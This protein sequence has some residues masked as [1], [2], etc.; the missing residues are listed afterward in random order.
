MWQRR[1]GLLQTQ[2]NESLAAAIEL[3]LASPLFRELGPDAR[4]LI[5]VVA[6]FPQG[7]DE[8]NLEWLFPT[9]SNR[10]SIFDRFCI[11]SLTHRSNGFITMLAPL[12]DYLSPDDPKM[13]PLLLATKEHYFSRM[14]VRIHP[15][16]PNF[17]ATQWITSEDVNVEHLLDVF[18]TIDTNSD[19]IWV[20]CINFMVHLHWNKKRLTILKP[21]IQGLPDDHHSKP[22]CLFHLSRLFNSVG[23]FVER[24]RL[25]T[26]ALNL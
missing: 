8:N 20:S 7:V 24:K 1:T 14:S 16:I 21:K 5:G 11:L 3:S 6:F 13:S 4:A 17:E 23:N 12:R 18:T 25:L 10:T 22:E 9:I 19:G 15:S 2:H 26:R